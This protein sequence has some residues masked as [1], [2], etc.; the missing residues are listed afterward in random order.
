M[1]KRVCLFSLVLL[2]ALAVSSLVY[3]AD[4][5]PA[6][7][8]QRAKAQY[9]SDDFQQAL[10]TA[11]QAL[12]LNTG[13]SDEAALQRVAAHELLADTY[14]ELGAYA[15]S[16]EHY[17]AALDIRKQVQGDNHPDVASE[18]G[19]IAMIKETAGR[20]EEAKQ[21]YQ[22]ILPILEADKT[23]QP[24]LSSL[25][26]N[27]GILYKSLGE[28][29]KGLAFHQRALAIR[30][31]LP[32]YGPD[33][34][35]TALVM[36]NIAILLISWQKP[37]EAKPYLLEAHRIL[38]KRL[39]AN[40]VQTMKAVRNMARY[41]SEIGEVDKGLEL[42]AQALTAFEQKFGSLH[43]EVAKCLNSMG[44]MYLRKGDLANAEAKV[45]AALHIR[46]SLFGPDNPDTMLALNDLALVRMAMNQ[47]SSTT[48]LLRRSLTFSEKMLG[49]LRRVTVDRAIADFLSTLRDEAQEIYSLAEASSDTAAARLGLIAAVLRKG[50]SLDVA[51]ESAK[52]FIDN[53]DP[54]AHEKYRQMSSKRQQLS[55]TLLKHS[56]GLKGTQY[57]QGVTK[58]EREID[59][60]V[61]ELS[62]LSPRFK[63]AQQVLH[64]ET[65]LD[66]VVA[67]L[68]ADSALVEIVHFSPF[69]FKARGNDARR[70]APRYLAMVLLPDA[71]R[72][73]RVVPLGEASTLDQ[74]IHNFLSVISRPPIIKA[75]CQ[76]PTSGSGAKAAATALYQRLMAPLASALGGRRKLFLSLDGDTQLVPFAAL[77]DESDYL[78]GRYRFNYLNSTRDLLRP[79]ENKEPHSSVLVFA[80]P[81]LDHPPTHYAL[82]PERPRSNQQR[83][84]L[85]T[86]PVQR[87]SCISSLPK[88][89]GTREEAQ[90]VKTLFP[91]SQL[92]L[93]TAD[94]ET[95]LLSVDA[96]GILHIAGHGLYF[97]DDKGCTNPDKPHRG[98]RVSEGDA[99][100]HASL[101][102][103]IVLAGAR[104]ARVQ[105][106]D[107]TYGDDGITTALEFSSLNLWG[108]QLVVLSTCDSGRGMVVPGEGVFGLR[109]AVM[110]AGAETL[111]SS[112]WSLEDS[113]AR[114]LMKLYYEQLLGGA[115]RVEA[116]DTAAQ[117]LRT[118]LAEPYY[119]APTI[120]IGQAGKLRGF[121]VVSPPM[122]RHGN[123][124]KERLALL[125]APL[126]LCFIIYLLC[127]ARRAI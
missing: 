77:H 56:G 23:K 25:L 86:S 89:D 104:V 115:D 27:M 54:V 28:F 12:D 31:S 16:E 37:Q 40:H 10:N 33:H 41:Y 110:I 88:L 57:Q 58:L 100:L 38:E 2:W 107:G 36:D 125:L 53:F 76:G 5:K 109:R 127:R 50:R 126:A 64:V 59:E 20:P 99:T 30:R 78:L 87:G 47:P 46:E 35:E 6:G 43:P 105:D 83:L 93:G 72:T 101:R 8:L 63:D 29:E 44:R 94:S 95:N 73:V 68:P 15:Q 84:A 79:G 39:G 4:L 108:T 26:T 67:K 19:N 61:Q 14:D 102:S 17:R 51:A 45:L 62:T 90:I 98:L 65:L 34:P 80:D 112:L 48:E 55:A 103:G 91:M 114:E 70:G 49:K 66:E 122:H 75:G 116:M 24:E 97:D 124:V 85:A 1:S 11:Q 92:L 74:E 22:Q 69:L 106:K 121:P 119:W 71:A 3:A 118:T 113:A 7:L 82:A 32:E 117:M 111:V 13:Q 52:S 42:G 96:P 81:D 123:T 9:A 21:L 60:L 120:V 18:L